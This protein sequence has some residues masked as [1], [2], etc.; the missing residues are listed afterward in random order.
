MKK[1]IIIPLL[2]LG[3]IACQTN[4]TEELVE[5]TNEIND[6]NENEDVKESSS[7]KKYLKK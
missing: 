2:A 5:E 4:T 3:L 6:T 1:I 7:L